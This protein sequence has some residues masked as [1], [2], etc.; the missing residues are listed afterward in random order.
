MIYRT[1]KVIA[2][3][4]AVLSVQMA[5]AAENIGEAGK[6]A[7]S[8]TSNKTTAADCE[9]AESQF[10]LE[11][12]NVRARL[13]S[14]GDVWWNLSN[15]QYEVPKIDPPGSAPSVHSLFAGA[16]WVSGIDD[17]GNLKIAA[18]TYRQSGD[19]FWPGPINDAGA[20]DRAT[21]RLWDNHFNVF[22]SEIDEVIALGQANGYPIPTSGIPQNVLKWP[23]KGNPYLLADGYEITESLAP[24]FDYDGDGIYDPINGDYPVIDGNP[25]PS[26]CGG[27]SYTYADQMIFWV[28]NDV[29]NIHTETGGEAI[30]LQVNALAFA[31]QTSDEINDMTFYRYTLI[32]KSGNSL[33]QTYMGQWVDPDLGCFNDDYVGCDTARDLGIVYNGDANDNVSGCGGSLGYGESNIPMLGV[34]YFEGPKD[35]AGNQLGMSSFWRRWLQ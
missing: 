16:L 31:F 8:N 28:Y 6:V 21:C 2:L 9:A 24:F 10:D 27:E 5:G 3:V 11:I 15:A 25:D 34:D 1:L 19:D 13:L 26:K 35:T 18:Q 29:G 33:S 22:G 17:G 30:G 7:V 20:T 4:V 23:A 14:G 32:N 12:N